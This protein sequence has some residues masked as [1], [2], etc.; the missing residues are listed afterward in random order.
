MLILT[1]F[2]LIAAIFA[3][4]LLAVFIFILDEFHSNLHR[5]LDIWLAN[6]HHADWRVS[7]FEPFHFSMLI[8]VTC[9]VARCF[10][11]ENFLILILAKNAKYV[12]PAFIRFFFIYIL[13]N[14]FALQSAGASLTSEK[15]CLRHFYGRLVSGRLHIKSGDNLQNCIKLCKC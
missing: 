1:K 2:D 5:H 8:G 3:R 14:I 9:Y 13:K 11:D 7:P 12:Y 6:W 10:S 4:P 15:S